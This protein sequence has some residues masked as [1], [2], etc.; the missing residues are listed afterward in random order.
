MF[1]HLRTVYELHPL[2][3]F[4]GTA[5]QTW[6]CDQIHDEITFDFCMGLYTHTSV[7]ARG[8]DMPS[9]GIKHV[10]KWWITGV[11]TR[12]DDNTGIPWYH[13]LVPRPP[14]F[15][16]IS[17]K[18]WRPG[19]EARCTCQHAHTHPTIYCILLFMKISD[20]NFSKS[21]YYR[22]CPDSVQHSILVHHSN[23]LTMGVTRTL[24]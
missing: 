7:T 13:S 9:S 6:R 21:I 4:S 23:H 5:L 18:T 15:V 22:G 8:G 10:Y 1:M 3:K 17:I 16:L 24:K 20:R 11:A 14:S 19:N 12:D 2:Q